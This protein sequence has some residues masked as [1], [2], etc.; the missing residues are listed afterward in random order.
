M[1]SVFRKAQ[2]ANLVSLRWNG[3]MDIRFVRVKYLSRN[4]GLQSTA[5]AAYRSCSKIYDERTGVIF[6]YTRKKSPLLYSEILLPENTHPK[7]TNREVLWNAVEKIEVRRNSQVAKEVVLAL[8]KEEVIT[9]ADKIELTRQ[10][11]ISN[12][13]T[14]GVAVDIN[15][16]NEDGNPHAHLLITTRRIEGDHFA[17]HKAR[18]L[19]PK[20]LKGRV[21]IDKVWG[22]EWRH[23]QNQY[24]L[25]KRLDLTV[26]PNGIYSQIH[27]G[28]HITHAEDKNNFDL[29]NINQKIQQEAK[30]IAL[31]DPE[32]V[33]NQLTLHH[34]VFTEKNIACLLHKHINEPNE[35]QTAFHKI[36]AS[37]QL[38]ALG[39][40]EN[41]REQYTT[42]TMFELENRLQKLGEEL[43]RSNYHPVDQNIKGKIAK[44]YDLNEEKSKAFAHLL[45]Q[46]LCILVGR[47]GTGKTHTLKALKEAFEEA[48]Y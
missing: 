21:Q 41:S 44:K 33:L 13:V 10:F 15:I 14:K 16:H 25:A 17:S 22:D 37:P 3:D 36:K 31:R 26:D 5:A 34:S 39:Q 28:K 23:F 48:G 27:L 42:R 38:V 32:A 9:D 12:F 19:D 46:D 47:A 11:A 35:F 43:N 8:P 40:D 7:F 29:W 4:K 2:Y 24:F 6:D 30:Q 18:D 20:I 45:G 1:K